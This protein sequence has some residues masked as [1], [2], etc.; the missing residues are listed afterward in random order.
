MSEETVKI[1]AS[2]SASI[3]GFSHQ[4]EIDT[5]LTREQWDALTE[6]EKQQH[7]GPMVDDWFENYVPYGWGE[8]E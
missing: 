6:E 2:L 3:A 5:E 1:Q 8:I 4:E 7:V